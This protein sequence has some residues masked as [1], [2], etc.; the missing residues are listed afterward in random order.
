MDNRMPECDEFVC[1]RRS[2]HT[3]VAYKDAIYVFGTA[4]STLPNDLHC[5]DL[6]TQ[7]WHVI[8][9]IAKYPRVGC[10]TRRTESDTSRRSARYCRRRRRR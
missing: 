2:K 9:P 10:F 7:T 6:D 1:A 8:A 4:D 3:V 5:Y